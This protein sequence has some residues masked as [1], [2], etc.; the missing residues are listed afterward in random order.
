MTSS[1][2]ESKT[3]QSGNWCKD[4]DR[5][6]IILIRG[7]MRKGYKFIRLHEDLYD[8]FV[9][10]TNAEKTS[11]RMAV[12]RLKGEGLL[13]PTIYRG[14]YKINQQ[15]FIHDSKRSNSITTQIMEENQ[16]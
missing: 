9:C 7:Y 16:C 12:L 14:I 3:C 8:M 10:E 1:L 5:A 15:Q 11:V 13:S 6:A 2:L 4:Y